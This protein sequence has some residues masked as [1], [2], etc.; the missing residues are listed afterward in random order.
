MANIILHFVVHQS[1]SSGYVPSSRLV[2]NNICSLSPH[3]HISDR[4]QA[5]FLLRA[6]PDAKIARLK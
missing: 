3:Q 2:Q 1:R 6:L 4:L 5:M